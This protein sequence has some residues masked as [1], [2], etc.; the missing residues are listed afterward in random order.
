MSFLESV[1]LKFF[2]NAVKL[3]AVF[4]KHLDCLG[5]AY[6]LHAAGAR[7]RGETVSKSPRLTVRLEVMSNEKEQKRRLG[8]GLVS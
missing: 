3:L 1:S 2:S 8:T 4:L 7:G 6:M 5:Q